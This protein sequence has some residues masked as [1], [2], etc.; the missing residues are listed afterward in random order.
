MITR[1]LLAISFLLFIHGCYSL[2]DLYLDPGI[3]RVEIDT[4]LIIHVRTTWMNE[5]HVETA[6]LDSQ[7]RVLEVFQFGR[8]SAKTRNYYEGVKNTMT[9]RYH[10]GDSS[11]PGY[12]SVDTLRRTYDA[13]GHIAIESWTNGYLSNGESSGIT[14]YYR[15]YLSC[16][17][18]GD[19]LV[20]KTESSEDY[21]DGYTITNINRWETDHKR[22]PTRHYILHVRKPSQSFRDTVYHSSQRFAYDTIGRLAFSWFE[23]MYRAR[24]RNGPKATWYRYD[25]QNRLIEVRSYTS[26]MSHVFKKARPDLNAPDRKKEAWYRK[27]YFVADS[28]L[29]NNK[30]YTSIQ[31]QYERFDPKKHLP[32]NVPVVD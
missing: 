32:L 30:D 12:V 27:N 3:P 17:A 2:E 28:A 29:R 22:R 24:Y 14:G 19:T 26:N 15:R 25:D 1:L 7:N 10:H 21:E 9:I 23:P 18:N 11:S 8:S 6:F 16:S 4:S 13:K 5:K 20:K 31:Y